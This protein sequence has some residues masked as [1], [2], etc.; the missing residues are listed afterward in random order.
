MS[1]AILEID[2]DTSAEDV[3]THFGIKGMK[4]G[5]RRKNPS[6]K[7]QEKDTT[8]VNSQPAPLKKGVTDV[9]TKASAKDLTD[10]ELQK[11]INRINMEKNYSKLTTKE[12]KSG[13]K[14]MKDI[15]GPTGVRYAKAAVDIATEG[16][17]TKLTGNIKDPK[18]Q[19]ALMAIIQKANKK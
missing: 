13:A 19:A 17:L 11:R 2:K 4:W 9:R 3:L 5:V 14:I 6:G 8:E 16:A 10:E 12:K 7:I 1:K 15:F 18:A